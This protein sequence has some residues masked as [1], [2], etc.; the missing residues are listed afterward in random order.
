MKPTGIGCCL[1]A[2]LFALNSQA[3]PLLQYGPQPESGA[4]AYLAEDPPTSLPYGTPPNVAAAPTYSSR[5]QASTVV[6][7]YAAATPRP[8]YANPAPNM[9]NAPPA[10]GRG[11]YPPG[12]VSRP[13]YPPP[14]MGYRGYTPA[15]GQTGHPP[16]GRGPEYQ[17][18]MGYPSGQGYGRSAH[19][20]DAAHYGQ[21]PPAWSDPRAAQEPPDMTPDQ[22]LRVGIDELSRFLQSD[23]AGNPEALREFVTTRVAPYFDFAKMARWAA[24]RY[25]RRMDENQRSLF[26]HKLAGMFLEALTRNL[27]SYANPLPRI[28][29]FHLRSTR[30]G[31]EVT[32]RALVTPRGGY[33][34]K[35]DF[36]LSRTENGEWRVYDVAANGNSAVTYYRNHFA[37]LAGRQGAAALFR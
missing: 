2:S 17:R 14:A 23:A 19:V 24:G 13:A 34:M 32:V 30:F 9:R 26:T 33:P 7:N 27:G 5:G 11:G 4:Q 35:L 8:G 18:A 16:R 25:F 29:V 21:Q 36:G 20:P 31:D 12:T 15:Y 37:R 6:Q 1:A 22:I 28:D 3:I 10:Y